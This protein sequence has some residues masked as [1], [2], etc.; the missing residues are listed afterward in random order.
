MGRIIAVANQKGGVGKTTT[1]INLS[2]CLSALGKRVLAIDM[3]PQGNMTSGLGVDKDN[4][5]KTVYD[6]IIGRATVEEC[7][8]KEVFENLDLLPTNIDLSAAEIELIGVENKEF[9][10]RDEVAKIRGNYDFVIV[11]C[12][13]SLS[14]L[15]INAMTTADTVLV[16][17]QC[18]YYALEGLSQLM[19]TIDLVK[20]RLN[21]DLEMEGVVFT[22]YNARTNLSLQ[23]VENVKDNLDQTIYKTIIPRNIRLAEAPSHGLPINIYDPKSSGAESYMLLAEEVIHKGEE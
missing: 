17:I 8:C 16:P 2:S 10:I 21:P 9:I 23:V 15:T 4:V 20:E 22:M 6:L 13:P 5:E 1:A 19:H 7:L 14:M 11:D 12:P 18:E 3:D